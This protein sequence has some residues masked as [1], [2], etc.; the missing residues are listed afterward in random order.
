LTADLSATRSDVP[1][2]TLKRQLV[3]EHRACDLYGN[4]TLC[5]TL[6]VLPGIGFADQSAKPTTTRWTSTLG[7]IVLG[8]ATVDLSARDNTL[9]VWLTSAHGTASAGHTNAVIFDLDDDTTSRRALGMTFDRYVI[10][11][12][13]TPRK[14]PLLI[15]WD[16][17]PGDLAMLAKETTAAQAAIMAS[18]S[19]YRTR[20]GKSHLSEPN[21]PAVPPPLNQAELET[22]TPQQLTL[23]LAN[24]VRRTWTAWLT[25]EGEREKRSAYMPGGEEGEK[26]ALVPAEFAEHNTI[27]PV[28]PLR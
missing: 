21:L 25:T 14:H 10:L 17:E 23:A 7:G 6:G 19:E 26:P 3:L 4:V 24:Q 5:V 28:R 2:R 12:D 9:T 8:F 1:A 18:F 15:S 20:P 11:T 22:N 27:V 13:R 16:V